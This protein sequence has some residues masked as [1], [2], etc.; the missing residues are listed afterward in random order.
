MIAE[1]LPEGVPR[2]RSPR[3]KIESLVYA[4]F[5]PGNGGFPINVSEGGMAF[6]GI[7]PLEKGQVV[8]IRFKLPGANEAVEIMA[9]VAWLNELGKGG[10]LQFLDLPED[11]R[12]PINLWISLQ[13]LPGNL[14]EN[15]SDGPRQADLRGLQAVPSP[16]PAA[17]EGKA[18]PKAEPKSTLSSPASIFALVKAKEATTS[19]KSTAGFLGSTEA[20][21]ATIRGAAGKRTWIKPFVIGIITS[22]AFMVVIMILLGVISV[23]FNLP[24]RTAGVN[25]APPAAGSA[26]VNVPRP[27][28]E[29]TSINGSVINRSSARPESLTAPSTISTQVPAAAPAQPR[30][31]ASEPTSAKKELP[32]KI[33]SAKPSL[34][35]VTTAKLIAPRSMTPAKPVEP[36][37]PAPTLSANPGL[38]PQSPLISS[39]AV[40]PAPPIAVP[41]RQS[42]K[43]DAPQLMTRK[44]PVYP[45]VARTS[46]I[47]GPVELQFTI[48]A[49][50]AVRDIS[51]LKGNALLVRAAVE[52]LQQWRYQPARLNGIAVETQSTT[53][54]NFRAN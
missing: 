28:P 27:P 9:Q 2:R 36:E 5:G 48:T 49:Q 10:G 20:A 52:A 4:D 38:T 7:Q 22:A 29:N 23:Q 3:Q 21:Q 47:S 16:L 35:N 40:T 33:D 14:T 39:P 37:A 19:G 41:A 18:G 1:P 43:F 45:Q 13:T 50:G 12:R 31:A 46:G 42:G 11:I 54:F 51:V 17:R 24:Q 26:G 34:Q 44:D 30:L 32:P 8:R 53:V 6:Q 25:P 15:A